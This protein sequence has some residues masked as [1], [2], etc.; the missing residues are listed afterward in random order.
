[1]PRCGVHRKIVQELLRHSTISLTLDPTATSLRL[2]MRRWPPTCK[3][4]SGNRPVPSTSTRS[5]GGPPRRFEGRPVSWLATR[6]RHARMSHTIPLVPLR[7]RVVFH[8]DIT[9]Y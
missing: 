7:I 9:S 8:S 4:C 5:F 2:Y 6:A 3:R 1:L